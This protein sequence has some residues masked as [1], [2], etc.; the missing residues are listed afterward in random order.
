MDATTVA[1]AMQ[2]QHRLRREAGYRAAMA[3]STNR[4]AALLGS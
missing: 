2:I 3:M 1:D 4:N